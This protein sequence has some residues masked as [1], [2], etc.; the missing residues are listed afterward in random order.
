MFTAKGGVRTPMV[1]HTLN[2]VPVLYFGPPAPGLESLATV[3]DV[4]RAVLRWLDVE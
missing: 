1:A 4:G 3:A 2:P